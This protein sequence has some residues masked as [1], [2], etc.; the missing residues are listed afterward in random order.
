MTDTP[1][2]RQYSRNWQSGMLMPLGVRQAAEISAG[3]LD[4]WG[5]W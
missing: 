3:G 4:W 2:Q 1:S 5:L